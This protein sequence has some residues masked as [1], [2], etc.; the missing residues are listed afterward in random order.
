MLMQQHDFDAL[1]H[2]EEQRLNRSQKEEEI[3]R[4]K[5]ISPPYYREEN[6]DEKFEQRAQHL[7]PLIHCVLEQE[8]ATQGI[9]MSR[10]VEPI[11]ITRQKKL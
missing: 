2:E 7:E 1:I 3:P 10:G 4:Y 9:K 8:A 5:S 11:F 6:E